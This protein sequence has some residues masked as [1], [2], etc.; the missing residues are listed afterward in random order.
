M[1]DAQ[2]AQAGDVTDVAPGILAVQAQTADGKLGA[3]IGSRRALAIDAGLNV[4]EGAALTAAISAAEGHPGLLLYTHGHLDHVLGGSAFRDGE[5]FAHRAAAV[6][7]ERQ[8]PAWAQRA[9]E[10]L[11]QFAPK[12]RRPTITFTASVEVDLGG[13][14]VQIIDAPGHAPGATVAYV[15]AQRVLFGSDTLVTGIPPYFRDGDSA[16]MEATLRQLAEL[17]AEV[18]VPGHGPIVHGAAQVREAVLWSADY[19]ARLRDHILRRLGR[20]DPEVIVAAAAYADYIGERFVR[21]QFRMEWRHEQAVRNL[22][23]ELSSGV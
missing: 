22:I 3:V 20:D 7:I 23:A 18:L 8:L 10:P 5:V 17:G 9:G 6:H 14:V 21:D 16:E 1:V 11:A 15:P 2:P 4:G 19:I 13:R 12:V